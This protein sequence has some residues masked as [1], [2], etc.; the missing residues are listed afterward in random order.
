MVLMEDMM[1]TIGED[2]VVEGRMTHRE[3]HAPEE[4]VEDLVVEDQE[5]EEEWGLLEDGVIMMEDMLNFVVEEEMTHME[6]WHHWEDMGIGAVEEEVV[7]EEVVLEEMVLEE[8]VMKAMMM[9][10]V[11]TVA[12]TIMEK[13]V[14][15]GVVMVVHQIVTEK[16]DR[17][18]RLSKCTLK[19]CPFKCYLCN[20]ISVQSPLGML[21]VIIELYSC[22][23]GL[24]LPYFIS[25]CNSTLCRD[26]PCFMYVSKLVGHCWHCFHL[27]HIR[28][29]QV[30]SNI[31]HKYMKCRHLLIGY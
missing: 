3:I 2:L 12:M 1:K 21:F 26:F 28:L 10:V 29:F 5:V 30:G 18:G 19:P 7:L 25:F 17:Y 9:A 11:V 16:I 27:V 22:P 4:V 31:L 24:D 13:M 20:L 6:S 23:V 8:M 14:G 15:E